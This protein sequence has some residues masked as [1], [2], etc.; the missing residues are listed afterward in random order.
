MESVH[1]H[2]SVV[3]PDY[4]GFAFISFFVVFVTLPITDFGA[5]DYFIQSVNVAGM[6]HYWDPVS[7][8]CKSAIGT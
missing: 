8:S 6:E 7:G 3:F 2:V 1:S 4:P 5:L